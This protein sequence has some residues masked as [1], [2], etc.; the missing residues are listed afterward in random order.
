MSQV[1]ADY[2]AGAADQLLSLRGEPVT[3]TPKGG[4]AISRNAIID[5]H[6]AD[7]IPGTPTG[8]SSSVDIYLARDDSLGVA[9]VTAGADSISFSVL[10]PGAPTDTYRTVEPAL[11]GPWWRLRIRT[12]GI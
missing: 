3:Y 10:Y 2:T 4:S 5:R 11:I 6:P 1:D 8:Y 12:N 9:S 7:A